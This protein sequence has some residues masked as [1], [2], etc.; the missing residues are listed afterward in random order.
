MSQLPE[1]IAFFELG[2]DRPKTII[3][4][5]RGKYKDSSG[6]SAIIVVVEAAHK[7]YAEATDEADRRGIRMVL[8]VADILWNPDLEDI[9]YVSLKANDLE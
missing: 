7:R 2:R 3:K 4:I 8:R 9:D 1:T 5:R 6:P